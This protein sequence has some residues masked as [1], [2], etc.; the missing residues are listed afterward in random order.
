LSASE[1][2]NAK[3]L[4]QYFLCLAST[5]TVRS[6]MEERNVVTNKLGIFSKK[7]Y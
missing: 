7:S 6:I 1:T 2:G 4:N 5:G 3:A